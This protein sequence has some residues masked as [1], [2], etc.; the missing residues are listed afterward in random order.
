M[1]DLIDCNC[2]SPTCDCCVN[3]P[4]TV[5]TA[6]TTLVTPTYFNDKSYSGLTDEEIRAKIDIPLDVSAT[7]TLF[8]ANIINNAVFDKTDFP[9]VQERIAQ[10]PISQTE[11][12]EFLKDYNYTIEAAQET[13]KNNPRKHM[14]HFNNFLKLTIA[15]V[16]VS[17]ICQFLSDPFN[18]IND[19][20]SQFSGFLGGFKSLKDLIGG[21]Q[22]PLDAITG[23]ALGVFPGFPPSL[24]DIQAKLSALSIKKFA[25]GL[26]ASVADIVNSIKDKIANIAES[27]GKEIAKIIGLQGKNKLSINAWFAK[28]F[29][30]IQNALSEGNIANLTK[31][32]ASTIAQAASGL[33]KLTLGAIEKLLFLFCKMATQVENGLMALL[34]PVQTA[35][36]RI[37]NTTASL[38]TGSGDATRNAVEAGRPVVEPTALAAQCQT[39]VDAVNAGGTNSSNPANPSFE[40]GDKTPIIAPSNYSSHPSP[41]SW[42]NLTFL[43]QVTNNQFFVNHGNLTLS[44]TG[45]GVINVKAQGITPAIGYYGLDLHTIEM[46]NEVA[47]MMGM[48]FKVNS[49]FRHPYYNQHLRNT[50]SGVAKKS[51]HMSGT[52]MDIGTFGASNSRRLEFLTLCKKIGFQ[53]FGYYKTF[54][55]CDRGAK[56]H[57]NTSLGDSRFSPY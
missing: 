31:N 28:Q 42:S 29:A 14:E 46:M 55:H 7:L 57:W 48:T 6:T 36:D 26:I 41:T 18:K 12:R 24:D 40:A 54:T 1:A 23:F 51:Q 16:A 34:D 35:A 45:G 56:R 2:N 10:G 25:D 38:A 52:A 30:N 19:T 4:T 22:N 13:I 21:L 33:I 43:P 50:T 11:Y 5:Q 27:V 39:Y 3:K 49:G 44:D 47:K 53:G 32:I 9:F 8:N 17:S 15:G 37:A 20:L